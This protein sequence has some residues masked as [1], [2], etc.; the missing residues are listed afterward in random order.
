MA[1][2]TEEFVNPKSMVTPHFLAAAVASVAGALFSMFGV[3]LPVALAVLSFFFGAVVFQ[4]KEFADPK[5]TRRA[6][7][8]YYVL[9]SLLIFAMATG[10][11]SVLDRRGRTSLTNAAIPFFSAA[12]AQEVQQ[13]IPLLKQERPIF[14][15]WTSPTHAPSG[16]LDDKGILKFNAVKDFGTVKGVFVAWG[17]ATPDY[18]VRVEVDK[19]KLPDEVKSVTW[20]LPPADFAKDRVAVSDESK[21][22][23]VSIEAW[24]PFAVGA[25]IELKSGEKLRVERFVS[26]DVKKK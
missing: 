22:F 14:Y 18:K 8:F 10:T 19:S 26:F 2:N 13:K 16:R 6:K 23:A 25:E 3:A 20:K 15:D 4:S 9:N 1:I 5:M 7:G 17:L 11:H 24:K 12:Y 21:N